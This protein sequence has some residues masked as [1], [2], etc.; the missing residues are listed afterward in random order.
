MK[1]TPRH[2][3]VARLS[4]ALLFSGWAPLAGAAD[5]CAV[6]DGVQTCTGDQSSGV[7]LESGEITTLIVED[8]DGP[9]GPPAL[10][11]GTEGIR[12]K[13]DSDLNP[14]GDATGDVTLR[15]G[16]ADAS[17]TITTKDAAGIR[18]EA[19]GKAPA[20]PDSP[21]GIPIPGD[22]SGGTVSVDSFSD[23]TTSGEDAYGI[24]A[25]SR[26]SGFTQDVIDEL[27]DFDESEVDF[28][29]I[30]VDGSAG[31]VGESVAGERIG[32][33]DDGNPE[34]EEG[35]GGQFT[36]N[37]NGTFDFDPGTDF[38]DLGVGELRTTRVGLAVESSKDGGSV[39]SEGFLLVIVKKTATGV[40]WIMSTPAD[41]TGCEDTNTCP[42]ADL[43]ECGPRAVYD[44]FGGS[45][46][47]DTAVPAVV[48]P[49]IQGFVDQ[50]A[51][52]AKSGGAG[53]DVEVT[54]RGAI[55]TSGKGADGIRALSQ[56]SDGS[57]GRNGSI[58]HGSTRGFPGKKGGNVEV[59]AE[60]SITT[61]GDEAVGILAHSKAGA[62]GKGGEG[63]TWRY[64]SQGGPG[65]DGGDVLVTGD[66][67]IKTSGDNAVGVFAISEG[68]LGGAGGSGD[69]V[70]GGDRGGRGGSGGDVTVDGSWDIET[71]VPGADGVTRGVE[72]YGIW[73]K[74]VGG[75]GG[76]G[77]TG[78]WLGGGSGAGGEA[79]DGGRV[80]VKSRGAIET[81]G[82]DAHGI[83]AQSVGGFGGTGGEPVGIF[84]TEGGDGA[85]AGS[86]G[87]TVV[88]VTETG[89]ITT[90][91]DRSHAIFAQ[92]VGGGG[93]S[94]GSGGALVAV[95]GAGAAGGNGGRV[96]VTNKGTLETQGEN[97]RGI[98]AQSIGGGGGDGGNSSGLVALGGSGSGTSDGGLVDVDN[99]QAITTEGDGSNAIFAQSIGGGGGNGGTSSGVVSIGG[100]G[101]GGGNGNN[102]EVSNSGTLSTGGAVGGSGDD[103]TAVF[104]Q[105]VG[106]GGGNGGGSTSVGLGVSVAIGG[107][108]GSGGDGKNV[109]FNPIADANDLTAAT[110]DTTGDRSHGIQAQSVGGGGGNGGFAF[111]GTAPLGG[112]S[113]SFALGGEGA[114]GGASGVVTV[115]E[116][117]TITTV[118]EQS[119]GIFAQSVGGGGGNGGGSVAASVGGAYNLSLTIGGTGGPG[120]S[121]DKVTVNAVGD[122]STTGKLSHGILAQSVGGGGGNGGYSVAASAGGFSG[123]V[124]LGGI[125]GIGGI[126]NTVNVNAS[127]AG[128]V[129][130]TISTEGEGAVGILAQSV[131]GGGGNGGLAGTLSAGSGAV[132]VSLGGEGGTGA[133]GGAVKVT[134]GNKITTTG[135]NASAIFA[136]SV[137]GGGGNGGAALAG[138]GGVV[139]AS[140]SLGGAGGKGSNGG[141]VHVDNSGSITTGKAIDPDQEFGNLSYGIF[142]QSVGGGGGNGGFAISGAVGVSVKDIPGG[143]AAISIGGKGGGASDGGKVTVDNSGSIQSYG[144]GSHAI[145]AQSVGGGGGNG[146]FAGSF[147]MTIGSG[148]AVGVAVGGG[149]SGGGNAGVVNVNNTNAAAAIIT[150]ADGADGIHAQSVGGGGGDGGF[151]M[152]GAFGFGA[153]KSV[154]VAVAI[155]GAGGDGGTG[156][157]V[158]VTSHSAITTH[159]SNA[160]GVMA[161]SVGG[162]GG[163]GGLAVTGTLA[164]AETAG[165]VGVSVGGAGGT[166]SI[167]NTVTVDNYG[168][169]T[170][171]GIDAM[172][173]MAQSVG[174]SG[175]NGGLSVAAQMTG[176]S[177]KSAA[178]GVS[179][180]GGAGDGNFGGVVNVT[181]HSLGTIS[182]YG[183]GGHG[184][185]AQSIGGGGGNGGLAIAA[186][187]GVAS[188]T[189]DQASKSLNV[190]VGV[191]GSGGTGGYGNTVHVI[192][193]GSITAAGPA[194]TGIFAQSVGGGGGDGGGAVSAVGMLT[195]SANKDSRS[196]AVSVA[197]GG[198]GGSGNYGGAVTVDNTGSVTT[199]GVSGYGV[200]AQSIG[201]GGGIGGRANTI[202]MIVTKP[203]EVDD[204]K[205][206][207]KNSAK[208]GVTIGGDGGTGGHGGKVVVNNEGTIET[209]NETS[210]G[211]YAQ[212]VGAGGGNGGNG[213]LG[214]E[215]VLPIPGGT[216]VLE[217]ALGLFG[218]KGAVKTYKNI[219]VVVGGSAGATGDG[220]TVEVNNDKNITT[221]GSNSNGIFAQSVG[222]GGGVGGKA[223]IG[224]T[225]LLGLGGEGGA[226][227]DGDD[228]TVDQYGGA[229][230][231]T[232]GVA[233]NGIFAQSIGG[234]GGIAGN[235]DR[236]LASATETPIPGVTIPALNL[237]VGLALGSSGGGGGDGGIVDVDV[238]GQ[239]I[240]H[241]DNAAGV[242]AQSVGGGGGM[243]GELGN[244]LPVLDLLS[245]QIGSAGAAGNA[246]LVDVNLT[247]SIVTAGNNATGIF[248]QSAGGTGTAGPVNV[249]LNSSILTGEELLDGDADRGLGS[250]GILAHSAAVDNA[251]NGDIMVAINST[252]GVVRGGRSLVVD[253]DSEYIG[254]GIWLMDGKD[255]TITN[256]GLVTTLGGVDEGFAMLGTGSDD[257]HP[258]GNEAVSN[259]GTVT[260][261][262]DLGAGTNTFDNQ[263]D[264]TFNTGRF[265]ALGS[266]PVDLLTNRGILLPGATDNVLST[267]LTG[268]F[269]QTSVGTLGW[270]LDVGNRVADSLDATE[271]VALGGLAD[272]NI[273]NLGVFHDGDSYDVVT[274]D[275]ISTEFDTVELPQ[276]SAIMHWDYEYLRA[277]TP[278]IFQVRTSVKPFED[279]TSNRLEIAVAR[280]LER[281]APNASR[282]LTAPSA[283]RDLAEVIG[284]LQLFVNRADLNTAFASLSPDQY[285]GATRTGI[286]TQRQYLRGVEHR[287][288]SLRQRRLVGVKSKKAV[289]SPQ[290]AMTGSVSSV[291]SI[292]GLLGPAAASEEEALYTVWVDGLGQWGDQDPHNGFTGLDY[293]M[294]GGSAGIDRAFGE[295]FMAGLNAGYSYTDIDFDWGR[296]DSQIEAI[297]G[298]LYGTWVTE[299]AYVDTVLSYARQDYS[300]RRH[301]EVEDIERTAR[302]DHDANVFGAQLGGGYGFDFGG[303]GVRPFASLSYVLLD[304]HGFSETGA[305]AMNLSVE[306]RTT[307]SLVSELGVRVARA[308]QPEI[309]TF[310]P[311]LSVAWKHD[312]N[313][314]DRTIRSGLEGA[315]G[316]SFAVDGQS[317]EQNGAMV[318]A[319]VLFLREHFTVSAE[320][321]GEFRR[322]YMANGVF[323]RVG[324]PF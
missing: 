22:E 287:M 156:N 238:D 82:S 292:A 9:I 62:G 243:L 319:G 169:I 207:N 187:L 102:V 296:G 105:S 77:G 288:D 174:G 39:E 175:G 178:V 289:A 16:N 227:G 270:D 50:L 193:D 232:F 199:H 191:G 106:G 146:G 131:G 154:N 182:T 258:G 46:K 294:G 124:A 312:Y 4:A 130:P 265:V 150:H 147:A 237:G 234:G 219:Q 313:V 43:G 233:S 295:Q 128:F 192:N 125:G 65:G 181:N 90:H 253:A 155:G 206:T 133:K 144:M 218:V 231:E 86:G 283:S 235:V 95:G 116:K 215:G 172:G 200:Y 47:P 320:Y 203:V 245:W 24:V 110:I 275:V 148:A 249:T 35:G 228:V 299:R 323:A 126:G 277:G 300:N 204:E 57:G 44:D 305:G 88:T 29:V 309:G 11:D 18:L 26:T 230:I 97:A 284:T 70:T 107:S 151:A 213:T 210:D 257:T 87:E 23:V 101:G 108:G 170:T 194:A 180:G 40:D 1:P 291:L 246:G 239:I 184:I 279:V 69:F 143:A 158:D 286:D 6:V 91:G 142:A 250:I 37:D 55:A 140:V 260:G 64:G 71:G 14:G 236:A 99:S 198:K 229:T 66:A 81:H 226:A 136:Q 76:K 51:E 317:I 256:N 212:S 75:N 163:N 153:E 137:G 225:G 115:N 303:V 171:W 280:Y 259:F 298:S 135:N 45:S 308:F 92:S 129:D 324:F 255:N 34:P 268:N 201:G 98:Y 123:S 262:V 251:N 30:S 122:I 73:G 314:D 196:L 10:P 241:G 41:P 186:Q 149:G 80:E 266:N 28:L 96:D 306:D 217:Q 72:A 273:I 53:N 79:T 157:T 168:E 3:L 15:S 113:A 290:L 8:L 240:T 321:L 166:G 310:V 278:D 167:G 190:G 221:H 84:Y 78:G 118:G 285:D 152:S 17:V 304:E 252:D 49:D 254:V 164:F 119:I 244:D 27:E 32:F 20:P 21:L 83:Y 276:N 109:T 301:L 63:G 223:T 197:V 25:E 220:G 315:P 33:D 12:F 282:A 103:A 89:S 307:H 111:S 5:P 281:I 59:E 247:G 179:I 162:G 209:W 224:A 222:G 85:S 67:V 302:S 31:D 7:A 36:I 202:Q 120:G 94:G 100:S 114:K 267:S 208:L 42:C 19:V 248:A 145:F 165:S 297:H 54:S 177:K 216:T 189:A 141:T 161:Q 60:G 261:S 195:D 52:D 132:G 112:L 160:N 293:S 242:F 263:V 272:I 269:S 48:F 127:G 316:T 58:S 38:D 264:A 185:K 176:T 93:G 318:G 188:G 173:I 104:L 322:D 56:G 68:G 311:Y 159:G 183:L 271:T 134:N 74:S 138:T 139:G 214:S 61:T 121:S 2:V 117:G 205:I 13:F 211:I 274:A